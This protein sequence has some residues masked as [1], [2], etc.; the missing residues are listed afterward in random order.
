MAFL[1]TLPTSYP[2]PPQ[3]LVAQLKSSCKVHMKSPSGGA[4]RRRNIFSNPRTRGAP[5][6]VAVF[7]SI[8]I[9][10][11]CVGTC[12]RFCGRM[13]GLLGTCLV[14]GLRAAT[15]A[16]SHLSICTVFVAGFTKMI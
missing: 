5:V 7:E 2:N 13:L 3:N 1:T 16:S 15:A 9:T 14:D 11:I 12:G 6:T 4:G 8:V 10:C